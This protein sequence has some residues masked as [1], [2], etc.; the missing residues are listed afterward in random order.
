VAKLL[1]V[2]GL[3]F[4]SC[5]GIE[6]LD[7]K[8]VEGYANSQQISASVLL[9]LSEEFCSYLTSAG[10]SLGPDLCRNSETMLKAVFREVLV[11]GEIA[12]DV[13]TDAEVV[14]SVVYVSQTSPSSPWSDRE[15]VIAIEW[16]VKQGSRVVWVETIEGGSSVPL[17]TGFTLGKQRRKQFQK[18]MDDL[19][20]RSFDAFSGS[21]ELR[22]LSREHSVSP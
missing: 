22:R 16:Q 1:P 13:Q 15:T 2:L 3:V 14:P 6:V 19:F 4:A 11:P 7:L 21:V 9:E 18:A 10:T 8:P 20:L 17:G 5:A 12:A